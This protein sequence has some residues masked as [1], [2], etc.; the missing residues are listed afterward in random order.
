MN[1]Y[2]VGCSWEV[3]GYL[4]IQA[5]SLEAAIEI[6][7]SEDTE[8]PSE[9]HYVECSFLVDHDAITQP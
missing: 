2:K 4:E 6:A 9:S 3:Y 5:D 7:E 1:T 8:L